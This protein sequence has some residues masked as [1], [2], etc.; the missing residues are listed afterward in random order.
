MMKKRNTDG[1]ALIYVVVVI[2]ILCAIALALMSATLRTLQAQ[3]ASIRRMEQKYA[4][5]GEIERLV[6]EWQKEI[7]ELPPAPNSDGFATPS[8]AEKGAYAAICEYIKSYD[9]PSDRNCV[10]SELEERSVVNPNDIDGPELEVYR[11]EV[12]AT[13]PSVT[14]TTTLQFDLD[15]DTNELFKDNSA[16][17]NAYLAGDAN[18]SPQD[19]AAPPKEISDGFQYIIE[20][21][22]TAFISY[23]I[24]STP[25]G[26]ET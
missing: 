5:Q 15:I 6:A 13:T 2:F 10:K 14:V 12:T 18:R 25:E 17:L 26:G 16:A 8:A 4:A 7:S 9:I 24:T 20:D 11:M 1:F 23:E 19:D 22:S 21:I 3:E